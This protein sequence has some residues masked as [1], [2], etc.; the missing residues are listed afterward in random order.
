MRTAQAA[1]GVRRQGPFQ[2]GARTPSC[3]LRNRP[4]KPKAAP[5]GPAGTRFGGILPFREYRSVT[6]GKGKT[7]SS[8]LSPARVKRHR[9]IIAHEAGGFE[10][11]TGIRSDDRLTVPLLHRQ[12]VLS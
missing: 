2:T 10:Q 8:S 6:A 1:N 3:L 12:F 4:R 5:D 11:G 9:L 7:G